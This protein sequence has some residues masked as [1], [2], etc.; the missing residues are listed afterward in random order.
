M[1]NLDSPLPLVTITL[2]TDEIA[3]ASAGLSLLQRFWSSRVIDMSGIDEGEVDNARKTL[4]R[5]TLFR[6][7]LDESVTEEQGRTLF[8]ELMRELK[9]RKSR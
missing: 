4:Q 5:I 6:Q 2:T 7:R 8:V 3:Q 9:R 1:A